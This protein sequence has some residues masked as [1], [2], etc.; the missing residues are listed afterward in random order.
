MT[1]R[2]PMGS[3][4]VPKSPTENLIT[5]VTDVTPGFGGELVPDRYEV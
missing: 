4:R 1:E 2:N 3:S 5:A